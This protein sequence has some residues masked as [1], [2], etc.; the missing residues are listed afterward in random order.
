MTHGVDDLK[1]LVN[2]N[3]GVARSN[4]YLVTLPG[5]AG[6]STREINVLCASAS[7]PGKQML[8]TDRRIGMENQ[9]NV[10]GYGVGE[11]ALS[12]Y[13]LNDY[14]MK[15]YFDNWLD[16]CVNQDGEMKYKNDYARS[17]VIHQLRKPLIG[18]TKRMGPL[19]LSLNLGGGS[20]YSVELREAFPITI[21]D[22]ALS[23]EQDGLI[24]ISVQMAYTN[25]HPVNASQNFIQAAVS[26]PLGLLF[27]IF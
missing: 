18:F 12:F 20:V 14:G 19:R 24:Q 3:M 1:A 9:K 10:Y 2:S 22:V 6:T 17:I 25:W 27:D 23:G 15:K 4:Q 13:L 26:S 7:L 11:V 21:N 5:I 16:I 8:T